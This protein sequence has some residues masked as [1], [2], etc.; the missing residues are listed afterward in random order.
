MLAGIMGGQAAE[1]EWPTN[2][3]KYIIVDQDIRDVLAE[4]GRNTNMPISVSKN[5]KGRRI[6]NSSAFL[7]AKS[8]LKRICKSYGLVW[9]YDGAVL[10]IN[11]EN[12]IRTELINV[13][14]SKPVAFIDQIK[15][16][17]VSDGRYDL[18]PGAGDSVISV[19]GPPPFLAMVKKAALALKE[20]AVP[21]RIPSTR[22]QDKP[23]DIL[24]VRVFRGAY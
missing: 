11:G 6:R 1:P 16:L 8:F 12:E 4:F 14:P 5:V 19:S 22:L 18:R 3:Y 23:A 9:Y 17:G 21:V 2:P 20:D 15:A 13:S 7:P 24:R 10:H